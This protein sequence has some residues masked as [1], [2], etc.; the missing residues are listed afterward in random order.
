MRGSLTSNDD[1]FPLQT[2]HWSVQ[3]SISKKRFYWLA[4]LAHDRKDLGLFALWATL[5]AF[6]LKL[7]S[8]WKK[9][10]SV[11]YSYLSEK[12]KT[13]HLALVSSVIKGPF[14]RSP[15]HV[16]GWRGVAYADTVI[17]SS[18]I[19]LLAVYLAE[20][21]CTHDSSWVVAA[22]AANYC[23]VSRGTGLVRGM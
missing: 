15:I 17:V 11:Q 10:H 18:A 22:W 4:Q 6:V 3:S 5:T 2:P 12:N 23:N 13:K 14:G 20:H 21:L 1:A 7:R 9:K 19:S 16:A 8:T